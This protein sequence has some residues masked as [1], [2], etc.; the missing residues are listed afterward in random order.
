M[1][2]HSII[3]LSIVV[4]DAIAIAEKVTPVGQ[5]QH[6]QRLHVPERGLFARATG[7]R[8]HE[9]RYLQALG[10]RMRMWIPEIGAV[11]PSPS[12]GK[13]HADGGELRGEPH[14]LYRLR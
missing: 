12:L 14:T 4:Q 2:I 8:I 9:I 13:R 7:T 5:R 10:T 1:K 11:A 3:R 6:A